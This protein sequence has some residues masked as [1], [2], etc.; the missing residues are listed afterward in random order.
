MVFL[1]RF[2]DERGAIHFG[3]MLIEKAD[4]FT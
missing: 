1:S 4:I 3:E 2:L